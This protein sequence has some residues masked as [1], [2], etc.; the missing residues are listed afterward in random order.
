VTSARPWLAAVAALLLA[1]GGSAAHAAAGDEGLAAG[2]AAAAGSAWEAV[3]SGA[4][5]LWAALAGLFVAPDPFELLPE[6]MAERDQRFLALM[7]TAGYP[8]AA[9]ETDDGL[10]GHAGYRFE[11]RREPSA[12]DLDLLRRGLA[13]HAAR[14]GGPL[15]NAERRALRGLLSLADAPDFRVASVRLDVLPWPQVSFRLAAR[16]PDGAVAERT[17]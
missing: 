2:A 10:V 3:T 6:R 8:V 17:E 1:S 13:E 11:Q 12:G 15:A 5:S 16:G 7:D 14:Y 4:G 9:I